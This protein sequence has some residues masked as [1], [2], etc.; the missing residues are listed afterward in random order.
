MLFISPGDYYLS[1]R[2]SW[3]QD[4]K[5]RVSAQQQRLQSFA[6]SSKSEESLSVT[7]AQATSVVTTPTTSVGTRPTARSLHRAIRVPRGQKK[8]TEVKRTEKTE[9]VVKRI[10]ETKQIKTQRIFRL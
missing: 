10:V 5:S 1:T 4:I 7:S 6:S 8:V 9:K 2:A 3:L